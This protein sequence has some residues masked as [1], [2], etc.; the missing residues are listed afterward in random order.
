MS[1]PRTS[2]TLAAQPEAR[3]VLRRCPRISLDRDAVLSAEDLSTSKLLVVERGIA[4]II[5]LAPSKRP[6]I[7]AIAGAGA[8]LLPP[9][10]NEEVAGVTDAVITLLPPA[11]CQLLLSLPP[12]ADALLDAL[13][14][15]LRERQ[16]TLGY[17]TGAAHRD[18]LRE[19]LFQL[20]RMHG[21]VRPNGIEIEVPLT[22]Q[23]LARLI[24]SARE[25]VTTTLRAFER[26]GLLEREDGV[27][28]LLVAP[29]MLEANAVPYD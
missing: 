9:A 2:F 12:A 11:A 17:T 24:G 16:E 27:Y 26:E 25:T 21:K 3:D 19:G 8:V 23:L 18:R 15:A 6:A 13:L 10:R 5:R 28:R 20:A 22:H 4:Q 29:S 1:R 7:L 14:E